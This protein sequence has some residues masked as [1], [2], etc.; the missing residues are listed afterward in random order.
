MKIVIDAGHGGRDSGAVGIGGRREKDDNLKT[1]LAVGEMLADNG[2]EVIYTR[3]TDVFVEISER[4]RIANNSRCDLFVSCHRNAAAADAHGMECLVSTKASAKSKQTAQGILANILQVGGKNRGV[5]EQASRVYVLDNT[6][7][8]ATTI[9]LGFVTNEQDNA[10]FD[11]KFA[12][13]VQ[14]IASGIVGEMVV[15]DVPPIV[16][17][18]WGVVASSTNF[19][20]TPKKSDNIIKN[21]KKG[22]EVTLDRYVKGEDWARV[23]VD[24]TLGYV[25]LD[26]VGKVR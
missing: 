1:A 26:Y 2:H 7:M 14:A 23:Y 13:Y 21:L 6:K 20:R 24:G 3:K 18:D 10:L 15:G 17:S 4:V 16:K 11:V 12:Q 19:R 25:W 9:E 8:P 22:T 5:K